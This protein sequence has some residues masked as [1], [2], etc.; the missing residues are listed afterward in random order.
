MTA[1]LGQSA[2]AFTLLET[3]R[4][5]FENGA[6]GFFRMLPS[7]PATWT[8]DVV[9][10][11]GMVRI[12]NANEGYEFELWRMGQAVEGAQETPVR[13]IFPRPQKLW[14]AVPGDIKPEPSG[15]ISQVLV[16]YSSVRYSRPSGGV[17][18]MS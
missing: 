14:S 9:G 17:A 1:V 13:H 2:R 11:T 8:I 4:L 6:R 3:L 7:G 15:T 12:R 5:A 18:S 10:E 16:K